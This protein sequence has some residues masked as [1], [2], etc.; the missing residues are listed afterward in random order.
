MT[1][2]ILAAFVALFLAI[3]LGFDFFYLSFNPA[4]APKCSLNASGYYEAGS[5]TPQPIPY[6]TIAALFI[7]VGLAANSMVNGPGMV[8]RSTMARRAVPAVEKEKQLINVVEEM[9][10]AAGIA[11][12][13]VYVVPDPDLNAFAT[14]TNPSNSVIAVTEGLLGSLNREELQGVVAHEMSHIRNY[15]MRLLT[16]TAA[17]IGAIGL[18]SDFAGRSMRYGRLSGDTAAAS[19]RRSK[20]GLGPLL[21]VF[22]VLWIALVVLAPILSRLLAM[23]ISRE[24]EYLADASGAELTRNPLSLASALEKIR[25]AVIPSY[26]I[27]NGVAHMCITDPRGSLIEGKMGFAADLFATHP[28]MEKRILALKVMAYQNS[29][30]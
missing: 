21:I 2:F 20:K 9:A 28:P 19:P 3:G 25:V 16:V 14:G 30:V 1:D 18:I 15:D 13:A 24:R 12:P 23:A 4:A 6:G 22:F 11:A 26:A 17:L 7:G 5:H 8:L 29:R 27:N 10:T